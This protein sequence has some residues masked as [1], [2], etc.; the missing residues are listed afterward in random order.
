MKFRVFSIISLLCTLLLILCTFSP[1]LAAT[2]TVDIAADDADA[3]DTSPGDGICSDALSSCTLRAAIEEANATAAPDVILFADTFLN[4]RVNLAA[5]EGP[6]PTITSQVIILGNSI[7]AYNDS[8]S[9]LSDAPP[10]FTIDG[11]NLTNGSGLV[12]SGNAASNSIVFALSIVNFPGDGIQMLLDADDIDIDLCYIGVNPDGTAGGLGLNGIVALNSDEH[13]IGKRASGSDL[14]GLGNLISGN[15]GDGIRFLNSNN[16]DIFGN[17]IGIGASGTGDRGN[18]SH[19]I[20]I[21][22]DGNDI[23]SVINGEAAGNYIAGNDSGGVSVTG[24]DNTFKANTLGKGPTGGFIDSGLDGIAVFGELNVIGGLTVLAGN[25]IVE[26]SG[27]GIRL[28]VVGGTA[29]HN[30]FVLNNRLGSAGALF[31]LLLATNGEGILVNGNNNVINDNVVMNSSDEGADPGY[32]GNAITVR[33]SSSSINGNQIGYMNNLQ[34]VNAEPNKNGILVFGNGHSIGSMLNPNTVAGNTGLGIYTRGMDN[35]VSYN[36]VGVTADN[37]RLG[38][39]GFG[40]QMEHQGGGLIVNANYIGDNGSDGLRLETPNNT[41]DVTQNVI[42]ELPNGLPAGNQGSGVYIVGGELID[43]AGNLIAHNVLDG[44]RLVNDS[45]GVA[46]FQNSIYSNGQEG[47]DLGNDGVTVN[48]AGDFDEGDNR[49][50]N[51]P[52]IEEVIFDETIS[53]RTLTLRYR[54]DSSDDVNASTYPLFIDFYWNPAD[55]NSQG[56][57]F[58]G[59]DFNYT[60]PNAIKTVVFDFESSATG[61]YLTATALDQDRNTSE[62]ASQVLFGEIDLIFKNSFE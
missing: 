34:G 10:Q 25:E 54:V 28:G 18:D 37:Q 2:F 55:E 30:N 16:N 53:P 42:G 58:I 9:N 33:G 43:V 47:I 11:S 44:I 51:T 50:Q 22:G 48:D 12:F 39:N 31:P 61:G 36:F 24:D 57:Y 59:T 38:N 5:S 23:G 41:L 52:V 45:N 6:L 26:H 20:Y 13:K 56:R 14:V 49:L 32:F 7:D 17:W 35:N 1:L 40:V 3:H 4:A 27:A 21:T 46:M 19:G 60:T 62:F 29:G 15:G 8:A